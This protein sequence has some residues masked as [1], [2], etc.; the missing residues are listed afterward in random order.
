[1]KLRSQTRWWAAILRTTFGPTCNLSRRRR[2][3]LAVSVL[4]FTQ[5]APVARAGIPSDLWNTLWSKAPSIVLPVVELNKIL[6][7]TASPDL[8][9]VIDPTRAGKILLDLAVGGGISKDGRMKICDATGGV[10][11]DRLIV[12]SCSHGRVEVAPAGVPSQYQVCTNG[13]GYTYTSAC[14]YMDAGGA[15]YWD[16]GPSIP[17]V[18]DALLPK[19]PYVKSYQILFW[20]AGQEHDYCYHHH[21]A[22][23]YTKAQCDTQFRKSMDAICSQFQRY[24]ALVRQD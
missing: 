18:A 13:K 6:V 5:F 10:Y 4:V 9:R 8:V 15:Y 19:A 20:L 23:G 17:A 14:V 12:S 7:R 3:G 2:T 21:W 16:D 11:S 24:S 22:Y 1:M